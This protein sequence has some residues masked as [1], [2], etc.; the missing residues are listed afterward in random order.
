VIASEHNRSPPPFHFERNTRDCM[1]SVCKME[2]G[3]LKSQRLSYDGWS[4]PMAVSKE[5]GLQAR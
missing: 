1:E 2:N 3:P 4:V 5:V